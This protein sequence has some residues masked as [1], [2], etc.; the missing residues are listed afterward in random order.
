MRSRQNALLSSAVLLITSLAVGAC[1]GVIGGTD[2]DEKGGGQGGA[3]GQGGNGASSGTMSTG[4][5]G[6]SVCGD[7]SCTSGETCESCPGDCGPCAA[8]CG[9]QTCDADETCVT[10]PS[11]CGPCPAMCGNAVCEGS[12][13][14]QACPGDCGACPPM[15]GN[16]MCE[17]GEDCMNCPMDCGMCPVMCGGAGPATTPLDAEEQSFL[18]LLNQYRAQN[19]LGAVTACTSLNRAAQ[20][21]SEDMR[22]QDYFAHEGKNGSKFFERACDACYD[23]GCGPKTAMAENIAAGN[24]TGQA[25]FTQWK[26]SAGHNMNMLGS[27]FKVIGIGRATGGGQYGIYWTTVFGGDP[28]ASCN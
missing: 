14:C 17:A 26:N 8:T 12:E 3:G 1:T 9:S 27:A 18:M 10:C 20:G 23:L 28:E 15:C 24:A 2:E 11:D 21:H 6:G 25:T 7:A 4:T 5:S 22:D 19:G 13:T 16:Q